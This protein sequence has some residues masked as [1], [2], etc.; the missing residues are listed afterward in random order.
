MLLIG[1]IFIFFSGFIYFLFMLA[2]FTAF[3]GIFL[4]TDQLTVISIIAG[5]LAIILGGV[6]IKDFFYF[7]KGPSL[8]ISED[9]K[10]E[11]F[12]RMRNIVRASYL[13]VMIAGTI[14][15]AIFAN[16]YE[17]FCTLMLPVVF[18]NI[19][20]LNNLTLSQSY[21]YILFYNIVYVLPLIIIVTVLTVKL[22]RSKLTEWQGRLLKLFSGIMML[23]LGSVLLIKPALLNNVFSTIGL[24]CAA[25]IGAVIIAF[26]F[27]KF[28]QNKVIS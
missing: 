15:L 10:S 3:Y 9:K 26:I 6:N 18:T 12:K 20:T 11:L 19:L 27:R 14:I 25:L 28:K 7:K 24:L 16:T 22:S 1:G 21:I 17:L 5:T 8:S 4:I 23:L 2:I 13:P